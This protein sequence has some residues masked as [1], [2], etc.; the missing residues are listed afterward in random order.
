MNSFSRIVCNADGVRTAFDGYTPTAV[1]WRAVLWLH[2]KPSANT[3]PEAS[4]TRC[5]VRGFRFY[6]L[7]Y[8]LVAVA[9]AASGIALLLMRCYMDQ[10][11]PYGGVLALGTAV[12]LWFA[13]GLGYSGA[14]LLATDKRAGTVQLAAFISLLVGFLSF[15]AGSV[16]A[17]FAYYALLPT[18]VN[19]AVTGSFCL[20]GIGSYFIE[21]AYLVGHRE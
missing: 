19:V 16:S 2:G 14:R 11:A 10:T 1:W 8:R 3:L 12:V 17:A 9:L 18:W 21:L 13:C 5:I 7:L 4:R 6:A 20:F 15:F